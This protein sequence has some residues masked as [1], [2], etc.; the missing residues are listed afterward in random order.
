MLIIIYHLVVV[1]F[2]LMSCLYDIEMMK[3]FHYKED[4]HVFVILNYRQFW[5]EEENY[6]VGR[7]GGRKEK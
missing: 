7:V 6:E 1:R 2:H 3:I 4:H 5:D